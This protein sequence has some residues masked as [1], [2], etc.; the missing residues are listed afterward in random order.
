MGVLTFKNSGLDK[1][2][3]KIDMKH[4]ICQNNAPYLTPSPEGERRK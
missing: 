3:L 1:N 4:L 2:N